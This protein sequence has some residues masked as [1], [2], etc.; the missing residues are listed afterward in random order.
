MAAVSAI[1][2][3]DGDDCC[4]AN[5]PGQGEPRRG[6]R[7]IAWG[8]SPRFRSKKKRQAAKRRQTDGGERLQLTLQPKSVA[9]PGLILREHLAP[10][11]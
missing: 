7:H 3:R 11:G 9:P 4:E 2:P 5:L 1:G 8:V 10:W 6:D